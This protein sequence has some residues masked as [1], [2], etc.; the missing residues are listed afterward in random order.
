MALT[1]AI[2][3]EIRAPGALDIHGRQAGDGPVAWTGRAAC[4]LKRIR[5]LAASNEAV[6]G[7][8]PAVQ[9]VKK[10]D[11][12]WLLNNAGVPLVEQAGPDWEGSTITVL[13]QRT[14]TPVTRVFKVLAMENRAAGTIVDNVRLELGTPSTS[15]STG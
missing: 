7:G 14:T 2:L 4:Y 10:T 13:D 1:N 8:I 9:T 15:T 3:L 6:T 5:K 11:V 12:L